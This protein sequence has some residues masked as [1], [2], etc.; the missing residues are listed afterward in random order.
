M[1][2]YVP[3]QRTILN[4]FWKFI[5]F[6][7][8]SDDLFDLIQAW[9]CS[10][11]IAVVLCMSM[12]SVLL[13]AIHINNNILLTGNIWSVSLYRNVSSTAEYLDKQKYPSV[14]NCHDMLLGHCYQHQVFVTEV[15]SSPFT[16]RYYALPTGSTSFCL[17]LLIGYSQLYLNS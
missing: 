15:F 4:L 9:T 12:D 11:S 14:D 17:A 5:I 3:P 10:F 2:T 1:T 13:I 6:K 7:G 8:L 16:I